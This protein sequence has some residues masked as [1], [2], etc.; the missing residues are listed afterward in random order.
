MI[1]CFEVC[2]KE[3][4]TASHCIITVMETGFFVVLMLFVPEPSALWLELGLFAYLGFV[5][6]LWPLAAEWVFNVIS[7]PAEAVFL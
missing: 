4:L 7:C 1:V 3:G 2:L 6:S 5:S